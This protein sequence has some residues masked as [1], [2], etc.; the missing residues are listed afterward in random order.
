MTRYIGGFTASD[1]FLDGGSLHIKTTGQVDN[2]F[3]DRPYR[4]EYL[5]SGKPVENWALES[6]RHMQMAHESH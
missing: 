1:T 3:A 6:S 5:E 2:R 4:V